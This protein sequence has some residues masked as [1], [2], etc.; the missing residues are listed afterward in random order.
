[1]VQEIGVQACTEKRFWIGRS[2]SSSISSSRFISDDDDDDEGN[3]IIQGTCRCRPGPERRRL[4]VPV[5]AAVVVA[6]L[7][8]KFTIVTAAALRNTNIAL[9]QNQQRH[10]QA[11]ESSIR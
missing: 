4:F 8:V 1:M 9:L 3:I 6:V 11:S 5:A 2:S 10:A 7:L